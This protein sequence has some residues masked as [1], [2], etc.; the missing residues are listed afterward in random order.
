MTFILLYKSGFLMGQ[1]YI[2][3]FSCCGLGSIITDNQKPEN[4]NYTIVKYGDTKLLGAFNIT[5]TRLYSFDPL[6][7]HFYIEKTGVYR[8]IQYCSYFAKKT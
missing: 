4:I 8:G 5:R 2:G 6:I 1:N 7:P 3:V